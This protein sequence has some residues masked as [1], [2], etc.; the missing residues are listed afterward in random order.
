MSLRSKHLKLVGAAG[1]AALTVGAL[2]SPALAV[3][4]VSATVNYSCVAL[5]G[6]ATVHPTAAYDVAAPPT[7][8]V[9]GQLKKLATTS[10]FDL[11]ALDTALAASALSA[12][13]ISGTIKT[14]PSNAGVGL[15][16]SFPKTALG[17]NGS[18][19]TRANA[20]GTTLLQFTK[21]G[22]FTLKLG[23]IGKVVLHGFSGGASSGD[24]TFPDSQAGNGRCKNDA[25]TTNLQD[26]TPANATVTVSKDASKTTTT[27]KYVATKHVAKGKAKV[28]GKNFGLPGTGTVK[29]ILKKGTHKVNTLKGKLNKKGIASVS[30][31]NVT[32]KGKYSITAKF[33][34]DAGLKGSSGKDTF[35]V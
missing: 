14:S 4:D 10:T 35:S 2:A 17:N 12:D 21:A 32:K 23:D 6:A 7:T 27:A 3:G 26:S 13:T 34:G 24:A 19:T 15:N 22:S 28:R 1:A 5:N 30:F 25:G 29:F 16:L 33:G 8:L 11:N 18:G 31:K 20:T 9:A